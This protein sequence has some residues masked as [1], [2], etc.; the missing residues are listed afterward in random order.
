MKNTIL[1]SIILMLILVTGCTSYEY[2]HITHSLDTSNYKLRMETI[3]QIRQGLEKQGK[4]DLANK[5]M[6][7]PQ[8]S[9]WL[10]QPS[11]T[12]PIDDDSVG[13]QIVPIVSRRE[14]CS[15]VC[16]DLAYTQCEGYLGGDIVIRDDC[17]IPIYEQCYTWC[18]NI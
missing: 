11:L 15:M 8:Y 14:H 18:M 10:S 7:K 17:L 3:K 5:I 12:I 16:L 13:L 2:M 1:L 4:S 9:S 6:T